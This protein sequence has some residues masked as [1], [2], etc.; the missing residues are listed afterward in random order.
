MHVLRAVFS[1]AVAIA[2]LL[3]E[4]PAPALGSSPVADSS[5]GTAVTLLSTPSSTASIGPGTATDA[6]APAITSGGPEVVLNEPATAPDDPPI[7]RGAPI[8]PAASPA[9][10]EGTFTL[11]SEGDLAGGA[12]ADRTAPAVTVETQQ[13]APPA[14]LPAGFRESIVFAGLD[15]PTA[16]AFSPDGRVFV[17]E[18]AG[19]VKVFD[20]LSDPRPTV[21]IDM[22]TEV[23]DFED[24]GMLGL[25]LPPDFPSD[26]WVYIAYTRDAPPGGTA[27][28][29]GSAGVPGDPC[30]SA[31]CIGSAR[32]VRVQANGDQAS[33][34]PRVLV[35]DWCYQFAEHGMDSLVFGPDG[36]LYASSGEGAYSGTVD[37]GQKGTP[38]NACGDPPGS[39]GTALAP[40]GAQGGALRAQDLRT[41]VDPTRLDGALIRIDPATGDAAAGNPLAGSSD[42][43]AARIV[44]YGLRNPFRFTF[45]PGTGEL[46]VADVGWNT[47]EEIDRLVDPTAGPVPDYGWP[48]YEGTSQQP[49]Y[50]AAGLSVCADLYAHPGQVAQPWFIYHHEKPLGPAD[51]CSSTDGALTGL[52]FSAPGD[53]PPAYDGALF[54]ADYARDCIWVMQAGADGLP[55]PS[56]IATFVQHADSPVDLLTGPG[57]DLFYVDI[58]GGT[59][60]RIHY[61]SGDQPPYARLTASPIG[62]SSPLTVHLDASASSDPDPGDSIALSWDLNGDGV[63]GDATG[64]HSSVR[65][66]ARG[67][68]VVRVR[69]TD[70]HGLSDVAVATIDVD[71]QPPVPTI[72]AP[73]ESLRWHTGQTITFKGGATGAGGVRLKPSA[74]TWTLILHH[75]PSTCH[76]HPLGQHVG[77]SAGSFQ[78]PD[79]DYP[80]TIEIRLTARNRFGIRATTSV[81]LSPQ[82]VHLTVRSDP[83]GLSLTSDETTASTAITHT[84]I[85]GS[86][87]G[88]SAPQTQA[89]G[90]R[91]YVFTGW[92][93]GRAATHD[94]RAPNTNSVLV[95]RYAILKDAPNQCA[96]ARPMTTNAWH[97]GALPSEAD[98]DWYRFHLKRGA[99]VRVVLGG[100]PS[101]VA[102]ALFGA[103]GKQLATA[104]QPGPGFEEIL[105]W[106]PAGDYRVRVTPVVSGFVAGSYLLRASVLGGGLQIISWASW[107]DAS[108]HLRVAGELLNLTGRPHVGIAARVT[109][110]GRKGKILAVRTSA[111]LLPALPAGG[112][113]PFVVLLARPSGLRAIRVRAIAGTVSTV[114][115]LDVTVSGVTMVADGMHATLTVTGVVHQP[116]TGTHVALTLYDSLGNVQ[117][118]VG[119]AVP[120]TLGPGATAQVQV[121]MDVRGDVSA[122][123]RVAGEARPV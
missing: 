30:P 46:W 51:T 108:G 49:T 102:L 117:N 21:F 8:S 15:L 59:V 6:A 84:V 91:T 32:I 82:T 110:V 52:A 4:L 75:C 100:A 72:T 114:R 16:I 113:T 39:V 64:A 88:V 18:K 24:R 60:R 7:T 83:A 78:A 53:F 81:I 90:G 67:V 111:A 76:S 11:P 19:I 42:P 115:D 58:L 68:H 56:T 54:L 121:I 35:D 96:G 27:P 116:S 61:Y 119:A 17:A 120:G 97:E 70:S 104:D 86:T 41:P 57:G 36:A 101:D 65:F 118:A 26:P 105:R 5:A 74:L 112:R 73:A 3:T 9:A 107:T 23:H 33:G 87:H 2:V 13:A 71:T 28:Y 77:V 123:M 47:T 94:A 103:C 20:S 93:D 98:V 1:L 10:H 109:L 44:A 99:H 12:A 85:V 43:N 62:G 55:D 95:A 122:R 25:A 40:P 106:L 45:R 31:G 63:F 38:A 79:H 66:T 14:G 80:S 50:R 92:S 69:A 22:R 37:Y 89:M 29:W 34:A 48:C